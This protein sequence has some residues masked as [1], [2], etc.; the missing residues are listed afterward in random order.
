MW[1]TTWSYS[2]LSRETLKCSVFLMSKH[3]DSQCREQGKSES[4]R[5]GWNSGRVDEDRCWVTEVGQSIV[6][7]TAV[8]PEKKSD[9]REF[10]EHGSQRCKHRLK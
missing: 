3:L 7:S 4:F 6:C 10:T 9:E 5:T 1:S 2:D 8:D